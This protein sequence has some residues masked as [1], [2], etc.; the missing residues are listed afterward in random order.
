MLRIISGTLKNRI[1]KKVDFSI[2]RPTSDRIKE[3]IFSSIQFD[4]PDSKVLDLFSGSGSV[5]FEFISRG[6]QLVDAVE[7]NNKVFKHLQKNKDDFKVNNLNIYNL[8][9]LN[10]LSQNKN[11][12]YDFI[13]LDPPY[14]EKELLFNSIKLIL[15][16]N[17]LKKSGKLIIESDFE[18]LL[19]NFEELVLIKQ[20]KY[21]K[22]K[23][24][25]L[26]HI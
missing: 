12:Q 4:I 15:K 5:A 3:A 7:I 24:S 23:I 21:T 6:S 8:N 1:I 19:N 17:L 22:T 20:K 13:F 14:K 25:F 9:A 26:K 10:F 16:N 11:Y 2:T 18:I